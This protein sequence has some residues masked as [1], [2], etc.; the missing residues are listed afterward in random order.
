MT[1]VVTD[2]TGQFVIVEGHLVIV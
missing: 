1:S 2:P